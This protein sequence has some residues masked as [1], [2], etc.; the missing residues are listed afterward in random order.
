M[1][2]C[3]MTPTFLRRPET[4]GST[5]IMRQRFPM[6][7]WKNLHSILIRTAKVSISIILSLVTGNFTSGKYKNRAIIVTSFKGVLF[8]GKQETTRKFACRK[9]ECPKMTSQSFPVSCFHLYDFVPHGKWISLFCTS[10]I[11]AMRISKKKLLLLSG[12]CN[13]KILLLKKQKI[14]S[15]T[16]AQ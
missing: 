5:V 2:S 9:T 15:Y 13:I 14:R 8:R 6:F 1:I 11:T 12:H 4:L 16:P 3:S 7:S 10:W